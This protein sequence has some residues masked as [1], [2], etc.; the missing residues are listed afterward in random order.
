MVRR[1]CAKMRFAE[2]RYVELASLKRSVSGGNRR[3]QDKEVA[4]ASST[5]Q[6]CGSSI[7]GSRRYSRLC[8]C[9]VFQLPFPRVTS[10]AVRITRIILF[11]LLL[12]L[13]MV[14]VYCCES[15]STFTSW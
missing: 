11:L 15:P 7:R 9:W 4:S 13:L 5:F 3:L 14:V 8:N 12:L 2:V 1:T 10:P 6:S